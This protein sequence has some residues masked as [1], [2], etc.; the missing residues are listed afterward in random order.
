M[1]SREQAPQPPLFQRMR[2]V[3]W[4]LVDCTVAGFYGLVGATVLGAKVAEP[5]VVVVVVAGCAAA[6]ALARRHPSI[7][8]CC[9]LVAAWMAPAADDVGFVAL[10]PLCYASY[11]CAARLRT[12]AAAAAL[13]FAM[14]G[15]F[16]TAL[17][18]F[19]HSGAI[20]PFGFAVIA[21]WSVGYAVGR[22]RRYT[23]GILRH[24]EDLAAA[25][26]ADA[27]REVTEERLR[28]A[29]EMHDVL[30]HSMSVITVQAAYGHLVLDER[31]DRAKAA[32]AVIET[33][34][35]EVLVE[36]RGML[37]VLREDGALDRPAELT[38][39]AHLADLQG[40]VAKASAAGSEVDLKVLGEPRELPPGLELTAYRIVQEALTNVAR[41]AGAAHAHVL[42]DF[43]PEQLRIEV[44]D[45]GGPVNPVVAPGRGHGLVGMRERVLLYSGQLDAGPLPDGHGFRVVATLPVPT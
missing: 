28:I 15:P 6:I 2:A 10:V 24:R 34:G 26:L 18:D 11:Q 4:W 30:A 37:G 33:T 20:A 36:M 41:H 1:E 43:Q 13:A 21:A 23:D 31:P 38:P 35:R 45:E 42:V 40:L 17:P 32:L 5:A 19:E 12:R 14:T 8:L 29:R 44:T 27:R 22:Q 39:A 7:G 3:H 9:A 25:E 16:A